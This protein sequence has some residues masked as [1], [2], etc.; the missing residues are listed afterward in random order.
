MGLH[1][2]GGPLTSVTLIDIS[3][4]SDLGAP[5]RWWPAGS[6]PPRLLG[7]CRAPVINMS[8]AH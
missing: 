5:E 4:L 2:G 6:A 7:L 8:S 3:N 1:D